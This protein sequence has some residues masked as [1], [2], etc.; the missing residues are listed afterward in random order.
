[1]RQL[2]S[3]RSGDTYQFYLGIDEKKDE[4]EQLKMIKQLVEIELY[5]KLDKIITI[6]DSND[7]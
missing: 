5:Y 7:R 2:F 3:A 1:M 6:G 4:V